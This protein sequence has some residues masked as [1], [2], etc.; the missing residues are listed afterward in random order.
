[1]QKSGSVNVR[2]YLIAVTRCCG[3]WR[4]PENIPVEVADLSFN[5]FVIMYGAIIIL[6]KSETK[7]EK[8]LL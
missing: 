5:L 3:G 6:I 4:F 2:E 8:I 1:M 7:A